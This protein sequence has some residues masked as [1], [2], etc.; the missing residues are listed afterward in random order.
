M[1]DLPP[2]GINGG[3]DLLKRSAIIPLIGSRAL[4]T[5][6]N[7]KLSILSKKAKNEAAREWNKMIIKLLVKLNFTT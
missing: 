7:Q 5:T 1:R 2:G 6:Q 3:F 4:I